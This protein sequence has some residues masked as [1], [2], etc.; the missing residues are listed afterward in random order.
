MIPPALR[1]PKIRWTNIVPLDVEII[2]APPI[3]ASPKVTLGWNR[4]SLAEVDQ[5]PRIRRRIDRYHQR[6]LDLF[7]EGK[8]IGQ[9]S[10]L[11]AYAR[12][13]VR[14]ILKDNGRSIFDGKN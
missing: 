12:S 5:G 2:P 14:Q 1:D 7:D 8:S 13:R 9:I 3:L 6:V 4:R 11:T 10:V